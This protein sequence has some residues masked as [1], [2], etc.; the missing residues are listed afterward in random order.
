MNISVQNPLQN[1]ALGLT[2]AYDSRSSAF[3]SYLG[4]ELSTPLAAASK[5]PLSMLSD[6][7]NTRP[8]DNGS[9]KSKLLAF[10]MLL[11]SGAGSASLGAAISSI[12]LLALFILLKPVRYAVSA[13][14][15][16]L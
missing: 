12:F 5:M 15:D 3:S 16:L 7:Q 14:Q 4:K 9:L 11:S 1:Y 8:F 2:K 6:A 13:F 10:C